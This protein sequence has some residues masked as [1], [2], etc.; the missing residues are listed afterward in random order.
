MRRIVLLGA[1]AL[2]AGM[3]FGAVTIALAPTPALTAP[4]HLPPTAIAAVPPSSAASAFLAPV[5]PTVRPSETVA[6][7]PT[8][9]ATETPVP[10]TATTVPATPTVVV[11]APTR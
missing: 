1:G 9:P 2:L 10:P 4:A 6:P 5:V 11:A 7:S 8:A 3:I